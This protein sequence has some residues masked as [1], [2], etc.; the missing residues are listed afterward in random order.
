MP[1]PPHITNFFFLFLCR[2]ASFR[3]EFAHLSEVRSIVPKDVNLIA[4]TAT[5]SLITK[6]V[7]LKSLCM[8]T[9]KT[10]ILT[11]VPNKLN[12]CYRVTT[13]PDEKKDML[14][15]VVL[16]I[17]Q[18]G[19]SAKKTLIICRTYQECIDIFVELVTELDSEDALF[20]PS[21]STGDDREHV[22]QLYT[23]CTAED[24]KDYILKS[25]TSHTG[26][27][28]VVVATIAFGLGLDAPDIRQIFHWGPSSN[29]EAYVQETGRSGRDGLQSTA[30]LF[31][32]PSDQ[33]ATDE[34]TEQPMQVYC[35]NSSI[36][37]R[38]LLM[39][40]F[41]AE[42]IEQPSPLHNCCDVCQQRCRCEA[43]ECIAALSSLPEVMETNTI[44][45][46][47]VQ[48]L[49]PQKR[50]QLHAELCA[51]RESLCQEATNVSGQ[52]IPLL[53]GVEIAT[54]LTDNLIEKIIIRSH[55][56]DSVSQLLSLGVTSVA[57]A[58]AILHII[59]SVR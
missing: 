9:E 42:A 48:L 21:L 28:R 8:D 35:R 36:C 38:Q 10:F 3:E 26:A 44:D 31:L 56:M 32:R 30:V 41:T 12:I 19:R 34:A 25:F 18:N 11:K 1:C 20:V 46:E 16:D 5:A 33:Q 27:V 13:K 47:Q 57:Q 58:K 2:G 23:A 51:Y 54:G 15:P 43:C 6:K 17:K 37:R 45:N 52:A 50:Q 7:I 53:F 40:E 49:D 39:S 14:M 24:T 55:S 4:L 22:C 59:F 29:I